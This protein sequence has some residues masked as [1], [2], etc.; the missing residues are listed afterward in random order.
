MPTLATAETANFDPNTNVMVARQPVYN[1]NLGIY[2]YEFLFRCHNRSIEDIDATDASGEVL[3]NFIF[4]FNIED[5]MCGRKAILNTTTE[6][7]PIIANMPLPANKIILDIPDDTPIDK[8]LLEQLKDLTSRGYEVSAGGTKYLDD[9]ISYAEYFDL[10]RVNSTAIDKEQFLD[11][12]NAFRKSK[13]IQLIATMIETLPD[14]MQANQAGYEFSQ[15]YFLSHPREYIEKTLPDSKVAILNLLSTVFSNDSTIEELNQIISE[16]VSLS[17]KLLKLINSPF[18]AL[19]SSVESIRN[20]LVLLGRTEIRNFA[21][22]ISLKNC[23]DQPIALI[24][25]AL[26]RAK[27]CEL[28][29][30]AADQD[31]DGYFT[32]GMFSALDLLMNAP[33]K[34]ILNQLPLSEELKTGIINKDGPIG[35]AL[36]CAISIEN[37]EWGEIAFKD[38]SNKEILKAYHKAIQWSE[39][40]LSLI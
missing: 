39:E 40:L 5:M 7:L 28:L 17:F 15:G 1:Q 3:S 36:N 4:H 25:I 16:D 21:A 6:F 10:Y 35:E 22:I 29:A 18:F 38:L 32:A 12:P 23:G 9:I 34:Q 33:I 8:P 19:K 14:Y 30:E 26:L 13:R 11:L 2:A 31:T 37:G 20:A 27:I 24:E